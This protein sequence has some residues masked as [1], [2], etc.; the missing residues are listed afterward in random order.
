MNTDGYK[1]K[2]FFTLTFKGD[3]YKFT[4]DVTEK[5]QNRY[6]MNY[7]LTLASSGRYV[8]F[9][10]AFDAKAGTIAANYVKKASKTATET[11]EETGVTHSNF[12][13]NWGA[14]NA[15]ALEMLDP[16][17]AGA[18]TELVFGADGAGIAT[19]LI[20]GLTDFLD[21]DLVRPIVKSLG[22]VIIRNA[23]KKA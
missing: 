2:L 11:L 9:D 13:F 15:S 21:N 23:V 5:A 16:T 6:A 8:T 1:N 17:A 20:G 22:R 14:E 12:S 3:V 7:E 4:F 18:T 10:L 19:Q